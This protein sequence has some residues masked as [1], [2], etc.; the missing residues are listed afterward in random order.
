MLIDL[1]ILDLN[2][3]LNKTF[4][5]K[6]ISKTYDLFKKTYSMKV[7]LLLHTCNIL[8]MVENSI[9]IYLCL[10]NVKVIKE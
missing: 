7:S 8:A 9:I 5:S 10:T 4:P 1:V 3:M 6:K 2:F